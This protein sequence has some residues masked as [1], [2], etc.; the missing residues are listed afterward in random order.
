M[1]YFFV[2][3]YFRPTKI[4]ENLFNFTYDTIS[5]QFGQPVNNSEC[6]KFIGG[7]PIVGDRSQSIE[8]LSLIF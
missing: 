7:H 5:I 2:Q 3:K 1:I 6:L 4:T 8:T